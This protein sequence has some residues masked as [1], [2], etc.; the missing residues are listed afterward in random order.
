MRIIIL[1][2]LMIVTSNSFANENNLFFCTTDENDTIFVQEYN[3]KLR[4]EINSLIF[5]SDED[6]NSIKESYLKSIKKVP[7]YNVISFHIKEVEYNLGTFKT[8]VNQA[9]PSSKLFTFSHKKL[10]IKELFCSFG[11]DNNNFG[12]WKKDESR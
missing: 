1:S 6:I 5:F 2:I 11:E 7:E 9:E 4:I 10:P 3:N 8:T 12:M